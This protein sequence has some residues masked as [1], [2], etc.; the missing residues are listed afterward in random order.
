MNW[1]SYKYIACFIDM[2][3]K[4]VINIVGHWATDLMGFM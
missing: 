2:N 4:S 1:I 3:R